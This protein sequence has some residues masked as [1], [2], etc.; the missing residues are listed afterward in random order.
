MDEMETRPAYVLNLRWDVIAW[1]PVADRL[2]EFSRKEPTDRNM[3]QMIFA[4]PDFR[5]C[6][7]SWQ[8]DA[9]RLVESLR[10]DLALVPDDETMLVLIAHLEKL[11]PDFRRWWSEDRESVPSRGLSSFIVESGALQLQHEVMT[12]DDHRHLRMI[13]YFTKGHGNSL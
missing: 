5:R 1:N 7:P 12:I 4:D 11:S 8:E 9:P 13:V 6:M 10:R 2:F 3:L